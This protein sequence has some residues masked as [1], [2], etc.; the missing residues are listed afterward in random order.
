MDNAV[1]Q[2]KETLLFQSHLIFITA[3]SFLCYGKN[4]VT[5]WFK[6]NSDA[7]TNRDHQEEIQEKNRSS[8]NVDEDL[9]TNFVELSD[10]DEE[11]SD[12]EKEEDHYESIFLVELPEETELSFET[13]GKYF[14]I[15]S[16]IYS[17]GKNRL[18]LEEERRR[19]VFCNSFPPSDGSFDL[20]SS[21]LDSALSSL[22]HENWNDNLP[23]SSQVKKWD[24]LHGYNRQIDNQID[25]IN[26]IV[27]LSCTYEKPENVNECNKGHND[28]K[29]KTACSKEAAVFLQCANDVEVIENK[30]KKKRKSARRRSERR[31]L[32]SL[33]DIINWQTSLRRNPTVLY[34]VRPG[35]SDGRTTLHE[36]AHSSSNENCEDSRGIVNGSVAEA[37][38]Q[39]AGQRKPCIEG[40]HL[41]ANGV[42][43]TL[44]F[45]LEHQNGIVD[46]KSTQIVDNKSTQIVDN[47]STQIVDNESTP[48]TEEEDREN[49]ASYFP[50]LLSA[51][52]LNGFSLMTTET[53]SSF[54]DSVSLLSVGEDEAFSFEW[55][56]LKTFSDWPLKSIFSTTLAKNG[57]VSLGEGDRARCYSCH[58]VHEGWRIGDDPDQY[59]SP[60]CRFKSGQSN[61]IPISRGTSNQ[62][63]NLGQISRDQ[64]QF[65]SPGNLL[66]PE[67][68]SGV[69]SSVGPPDPV[70][71]LSDQ[72]L[73]RPQQDSFLPQESNLQQQETRDTNTAPLT[74]N[75][76]VIPR[77]QLSAGLPTSEAVAAPTPRNT[78]SSRHTGTPRNTGTPTPQVPTDNLHSTAAA[79]APSPHSKE[80]QL[81]ALKR[82]PMGI[83]F[84]R[85][86]YPSYAI[87]AVRISSY[88]DWPAAMTQ[89][90]RDMALAGFFYAGYGDYTRCFFCGGGLRNWEAGDDPWVE[91]ARW[92]KKCAFVR[93]NRGQEFI[94]LVQK[95]AAELDEQGNQEEVG[96]QQT[97]TAISDPNSAQ[98]K[99]EKV[100]KSPAVTT[101]KEMGYSEDKI[102]AA[103]HTIKSRLPR[104]KHKVS[105]QE[106]LEVIFELNQSESG[107]PVGQSER[108]S[109]N[110][111]NST[112]QSDS[113]A[114]NTAHHM[115]QSDPA[116]EGNQNSTNEAASAMEGSN[117][118]QAS[119]DEHENRNSL[120][121]PYFDEL[122]SLK[123]ENTSLKDQILCKICMEKNVS[124]AFLP[125]GHL[126]CC[127]D[128]APAMR[129][130]PIC[131]EF[132]RGT[133]KTF[134]V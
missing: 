75:Q 34:D 128:C 97:N 79:E 120:P 117:N 98:A 26:D 36:M 129:K 49:G 106:I 52:A 67:I 23:V 105:A 124:I 51:S 68:L 91:H 100:M 57:W 115:G 87:L 5:Q 108:V 103:I 41:H 6:I 107:T 3:C 20:G 28:L 89:T 123:Q 17:N 133:V 111:T 47:K 119:L 70:Q 46:Y 90:P 44:E 84:D 64:Q 72:G 14:S 48:A 27:A 40:D 86:K 45:P 58:V 74:E 35:V 12:E 102:K 113:T 126:A 88:T 132:V 63:P 33:R 55:I 56:R 11:L 32:R 4:V 76:N 78:D 66:Y 101:I 127:E 130:C 93:Q 77:Q 30:P 22:K 31:T 122:T 71:G 85:P 83:N 94:D 2:R 73:N 99:E 69:A 16:G 114:E 60:N 112:N 9:E 109:E 65:P 104:G 8:E 53:L 38:P 25:I 18:E 134:L 13:E 118:D 24:L 95:R 29:S 81:E 1:N 121:N 82:D 37:Q 80:A 92:F 110:P 19:K 43:E 50:P 54:F 62:T 125:C 7:E 39:I 59:H 96:N 131:R 15:K 42:Q 21:E 116:P 10:L 61:N